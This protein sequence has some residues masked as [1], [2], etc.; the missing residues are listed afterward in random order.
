MMRRAITTTLRKV[1]ALS[2]G[3][4]AGAGTPPPRDAGGDDARAVVSPRA[5]VSPLRLSDGSVIFSKIKMS[6][7]AQV[8]WTWKS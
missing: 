3:V 7:L 2:P 5:F 8:Q 4:P 6:G 1:V